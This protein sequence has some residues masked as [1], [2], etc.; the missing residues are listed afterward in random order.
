[1][2]VWLGNDCKSI[3]RP[4]WAINQACR[5]VGVGCLYFVAHS[6]RLTLAKGFETAFGGVFRAFFNLYPST[7]LC[8]RAAK[9]PTFPFPS[10]PK[11][12]RRHAF[13]WAVPGSVIPQPTVVQPKP[14][15]DGCDDN[16]RCRSPHKATPELPFTKVDVAPGNLPSL[17]RTRLSNA[18]AID[19]VSA[20]AD[21]PKETECRPLGMHDAQEFVRSNTDWTGWCSVRAGVFVLRDP[22]GR[23]SSGKRW[24]PGFLS[25]H[26]CLL[27]DGANLVYVVSPFTS[28]RAI[29]FKN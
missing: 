25:S 26:V 12:G 5:N 6:K 23:N 19:F 18:E 10:V 24:S 9:V 22:L 7:I 8:D 2:V 27:G 3:K 21:S 13:W 20:S 11:G 16:D 4:F 28:T 17:S 29:F 15:P 14:E 1:M